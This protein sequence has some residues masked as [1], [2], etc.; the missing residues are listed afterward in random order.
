LDY[1][2]DRGCLPYLLAEKTESSAMGDLHLTR[3]VPYVEDA[4]SL[5]PYF[6]GAPPRP[7]PWWRGHYLGLGRVDASGNRCSVQMVGG[8]AEDY[9][10]AVESVLD[11]RF[12][13]DRESSASGGEVPPPAQPGRCNGGFRYRFSSNAT[14]FPPF[15]VFDVELTRLGCDAAFV[16]GGNP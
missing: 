16:V 14:T 11:R 3:V 8:R 1:V 13:P 9:R 4:L 10:A 7:R 12:G 2:L 5:L 6:N 15:S